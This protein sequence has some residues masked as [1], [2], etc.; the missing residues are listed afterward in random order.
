MTDDG[1]PQRIAD[2]AIAELTVDGRLIYR[3][4][5]RREADLSDVEAAGV[6]VSLRSLADQL[7]DAALDE[8]ASA[9]LEATDHTF[10]LD[11]LD[12]PSNV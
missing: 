6:I 4:E 8:P 9:V 11:D 5:Q 3:L 2:P 10:D 12:D 1:A 7:E